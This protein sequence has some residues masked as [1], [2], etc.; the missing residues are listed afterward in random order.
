MKY[1]AKHCREKKN[2][3][4]GEKV[5][6]CTYTLTIRILTIH[7]F[8]SNK[9]ESEILLVDA[10]RETRTDH[11]GEK[12]SH[13]VKGLNKVTSGCFPFTSEEI[14]VAKQHFFVFHFHLSDTTIR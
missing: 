14:K 6:D 9:D 13:W 8:M 7:F 10:R 11:L 1:T 12:Q 3:I 4:Q 5:K 2:Y